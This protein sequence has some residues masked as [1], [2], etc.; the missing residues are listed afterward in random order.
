MTANVRTL[1]AFGGFRSCQTLQVSP[2]RVEAIDR[3]WGIF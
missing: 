1:P 2:V 3:T